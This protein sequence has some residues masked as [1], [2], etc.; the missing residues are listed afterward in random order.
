M[1]L[2]FNF[3]FFLVFKIYTQIHTTK[4]FFFLYFN[5]LFRNLQEICKIPKTQIPKK[6]TTQTK[7]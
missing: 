6:L 5:Y 7:I 4:T 1:D 3:D 2:G